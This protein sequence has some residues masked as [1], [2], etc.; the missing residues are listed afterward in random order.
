V[1]FG[2]PPPAPPGAVVIIIVAII[3]VIVVP[4]RGRTLGSP[5]G[6]VFLFTRAAARRRPRR[7]F[8][9][10]FFMSLL[11]IR[12]FTPLLAIRIFTPLL[13]APHRWLIA[14]TFFAAGSECRL[15]ARTF[16]ALANEVIRNSQG[17]VT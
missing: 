13:L 4:A 1:G 6:C 11:A 5:F 12:I 3:I 2:R 15:A 8:T 7:F 9:I 17:T 10:G 14:M 16:H